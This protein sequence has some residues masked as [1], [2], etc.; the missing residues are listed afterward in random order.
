MALLTVAVYMQFEC[1]SAAQKVLQELGVKNR[2]L[3]MKCGEM[4]KKANQPVQISSVKPALAAAASVLSIFYCS[5]WFMLVYFA[6]I[7]DG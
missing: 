2:C 1:A 6:T 4:F 5:C 7:I 3:Q